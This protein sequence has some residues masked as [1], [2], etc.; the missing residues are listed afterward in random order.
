MLDSFT[1][2]G[3]TGISSVYN[4]YLWETN[5]VYISIYDEENDTILTG[6]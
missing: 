4:Y 5:S 2:T 6:R 1:H 3:L